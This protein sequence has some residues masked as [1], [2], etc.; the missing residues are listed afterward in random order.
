MLVPHNQK[1]INQY[2]IP[3]WL[4]GCLILAF[5]SSV[6]YATHMYFD[7]KYTRSDLERLKHVEKINRV[8]S[9][10]IAE[11]LEKTRIMEETIA[12]VE[13]LDRQVREMV[14]LE[15]EEEIEIT[16]SS[17][18][19]TLALQHRGGGINRSGTNRYYEDNIELLDVLNKD[20]EFLK[21][22]AEKQQDNLSQLQVEV[23][24]Q[25]KYLAAKPDKWP[26]SGRITSK[27]GYRKSPFGTGRREFHDGLD[28]AASYGTNI[29]A[30]G[31]GKVIFSGWAPG[32]GRMVSINH[33]YGYVSHYA[34][35][36]VNLVKQGDYVKKGEKIARIGTSGRS[37]GPHVHFMIDYNGK[38]INPLEVLK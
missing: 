27:F 35:N 4:V 36:S 23:S 30:A 5:F 28:I 38:R 37:T 16:P 21:E 20:L 13:E 34:H 18:N 6:G 10:K 9:E 22:M 14:G 29:Y 24:D 32:Y 1:S 11:L 8:Q 25:L 12:E 7:L 31:E 19:D 3:L 26:V 33:G 17:I 2:K 15:V